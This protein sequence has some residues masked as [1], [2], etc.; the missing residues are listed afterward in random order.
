MIMRFEKSSRS[1]A[2]HSLAPRDEKNGTFV[3]YQIERS[4]Q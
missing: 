2:I 4:D 3:S 1:R